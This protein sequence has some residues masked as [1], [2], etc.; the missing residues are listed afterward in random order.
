MC[1]GPGP[2]H[3]ALTFA[4]RARKSLP[5][6]SCVVLGKVEEPRLSEDEGRDKSSQVRQQ[7]R[8]GFA[9]TLE[10]SKFQ[11]EG[12]AKDQGFSK[13]KRKGYTRFSAYQQEKAKRGKVIG[14]SGRT[15]QSNTGGEGQTMGKEIEVQSLRR[16]NLGF[17]GGVLRAVCENVGQG[18]W[19]GHRITTKANTLL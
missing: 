16:E 12:W 1:R 18:G 4:P 5:E 6:P 7:R 8:I 17:G 19:G 2:A 3:R 11:R 9:S 10:R 14:D 13:G 15:E